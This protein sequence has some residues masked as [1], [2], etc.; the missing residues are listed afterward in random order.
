MKQQVQ[1][2]RDLFVFTGSL[3]ANTATGGSLQCAGFA[4]LIGGF[5]SDQSSSGTASGVRVEQS[6]DGG[7]T[8]D[9]ISVSAHASACAASSYDVNIFGDAVKFTWENGSTSAACA[10]MHLYLRPE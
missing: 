5:R 7:L 10:R 1:R 8:W 3:T 2:Y 6:M 4:K 9:F